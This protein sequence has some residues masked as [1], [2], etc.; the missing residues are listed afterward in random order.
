[1]EHRQW[2]DGVDSKPLYGWTMTSRPPI[3]LASASPRRRE[4]CER[5]GFVP[6][7]IVSQIPEERAAGESPAD[8]TRR[9]ARAK[10]RDVAG[11]IGRDDSRP[12]FIL[13]A[14]TIVVH[15]K[16]VLEKP[17]DAE[18]AV[19][20]LSAMSGE[21]HTVITAYC[22]HD[23]TESNSE[24]EH[25]ETDVKLRDL[26]DRLIERYVATGEPM[27][28]AGGYGIQDLGSMLVRELNGSYFNVVGLPI[29]EVVETIEQLGVLQVHP[30]L[31]ASDGPLDPS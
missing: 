11:Q 26:P 28:K 19:E 17:A 2:R 31:E 8:Y 4:L 30:L 5:V 25:L 27:D 22:W 23:R 6:E 12:R 21:W 1:M 10:A 24:V 14:D 13:A 15:R 29:C 3:V 20:M 9:L 7:V 16:R 18:E